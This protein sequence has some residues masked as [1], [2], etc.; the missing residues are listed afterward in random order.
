MTR[1]LKWLLAP[2][3]VNWLQPFY[4]KLYLFT[5][6]A[7][8]YGGGSY[9]EDSGEAFVLQYI[10]QKTGSQPVTVFDVGANVGSY[11][12]MVLK[13]FGQRATVHC[14]EPAR[15][16]FQTLTQSVTASN[17][18]KHPFGLSSKTGQLSLYADADQSGMTSVYSRDLEHLNISFE[19]VEVASFSTA[20][21]FCREQ[22]INHID[23][24]KID[25]EGHEF[26]V[27]EGAAQLLRDQRIRF[28]QFEF[29][30]TNIDSRTFFRDFW[31]ILHPDFTLYRIVGNGLR[32]IDQYSE[33]LEIFVAVN[34]FAERKSN[35]A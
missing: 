20:D 1:F 14:F 19:S 28:I 9:T 5:L 33:L 15:N 21:E 27:L 30:G 4:E 7:M 13:T 3:R 18:Q 31:K 29:G 25:V 16:T 2:M 35:P 32:R 12:R 17:V 6:Y 11:A 22:G 23:L 10:A 24:L 34:Y 8:N 26:S